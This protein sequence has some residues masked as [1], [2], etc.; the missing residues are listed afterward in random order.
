M[1]NNTRTTQ[2]RKLSLDKQTLRELARDDLAQ[3]AG[4]RINLSRVTECE[5]DTLYNCA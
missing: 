5:C 2:T 4:G 3:V 1:K